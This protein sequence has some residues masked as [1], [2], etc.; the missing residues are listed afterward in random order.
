M[1][2]TEPGRV[3]LDGEGRNSPFTATV[4]RNIQRPGM[5]ITD[6]MVAA[7][8]EVLRLTDGQQVP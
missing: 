1:F 8:K 7:R 5:Q 3:A 6:M 2:A 4:L